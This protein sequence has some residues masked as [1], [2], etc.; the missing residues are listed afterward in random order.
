MILLDIQ[1][2]LLCLQLCLALHLLLLLP[3]HHLCSCV[4]GF[5][6]SSGFILLTATINICPRTLFFASR[7]RGKGLG[8]LVYSDQAVS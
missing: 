5:L 4:L 2:F 6:G 1:R 8:L 3:Y 7:R